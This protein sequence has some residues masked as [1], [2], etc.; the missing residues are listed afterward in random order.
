[1]SDYKVMLSQDINGALKTKTERSWYSPDRC[2]LM[3]TCPLEG[4]CSDFYSGIRFMNESEQDAVILPTI[5]FT[6]FLVRS[7][8]RKRLK[9]T[10]HAE[11]DKL[12]SDGHERITYNFLDGVPALGETVLEDAWIRTTYPF[13]EGQLAGD[14]SKVFSGTRMFFRELEKAGVE[15]PKVITE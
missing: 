2:F 12:F 10:L 15:I 11:G 14:V 1:M 5:D 8:D 13:A 7:G 6:V 9:I 3:G 4:D